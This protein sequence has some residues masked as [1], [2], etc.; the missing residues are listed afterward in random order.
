ME[1]LAVGDV[2]PIATFRY[3]QT[4]DCGACSHGQLGVEL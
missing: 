1:V 3:A 4:V 2:G